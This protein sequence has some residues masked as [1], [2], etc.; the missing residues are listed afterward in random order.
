MQHTT[1]ENNESQDNP[2]DTDVLDLDN[3]DSE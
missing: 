2:Q 3:Y 1:L